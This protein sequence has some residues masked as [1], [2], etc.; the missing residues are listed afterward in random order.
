MARKAIVVKSEKAKRKF[1][2]A[3]KNGLK[4]KFS[5]KIYNRCGSCGRPRGFIGDFG[6][7]RICVNELAREGVI[8][9]LRKSSW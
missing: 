1:F 9:G 6:L 7:C 3:K 2:E 5:T 4:P 8:P